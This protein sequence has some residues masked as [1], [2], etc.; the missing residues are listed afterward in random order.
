[1]IEKTKRCTNCGKHPF[2]D[3]ITDGVT[4]T[5]DNGWVKKERESD[6]KLDYRAGEIFRFEKL[7]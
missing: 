1:M 3:D 6:T 4:P 5:C 7:K 2:C